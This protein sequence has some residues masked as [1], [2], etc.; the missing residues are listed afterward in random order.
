MSVCMCC[1]SISCFINIIH[2]CLKLK[3]FRCPVGG[4]GNGVRNN[5]ELFIA[6][7]TSPLSSSPRD[8]NVS[9][10]VTKLHFHQQKILRLEWRDW[11][12]PNSAPRRAVDF[13]NYFYYL[14]Q[15]MQRC[16][17]SG[18][19]SAL[20]ALHKNHVKS[21]CRTQHSGAIKCSLAK[22]VRE[23]TN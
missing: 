12:L 9:Q 4:C 1:F 21:C 15:N 8:G 18:V 11:S 13:V 10:Y 14:K 20:G 23:Q 19:L 16:I 6:N 5:V 17:K 2:K 7:Q 3:R 22:K